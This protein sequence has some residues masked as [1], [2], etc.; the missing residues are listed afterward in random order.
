MLL[1]EENVI[2]LFGRVYVVSA[3]AGGWWL[4]AGE[5][6]RATCENN[7]TAD[8]DSRTKERQNERKRRQMKWKNVIDTQRVF[9]S[10]FYTLV[11]LP[12][13]PPEWQPVHNVAAHSVRCS[14]A[15]PLFA[16]CSVFSVIYLF[17]IR[18]RDGRAGAR[19]D[20][21]N[22][23]VCALPE[24]QPARVTLWRYFKCTQ[25]P[26][27]RSRHTHQPRSHSTILPN[28]HMHIYM[29]IARLITTQN[30]YATN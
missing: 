2:N 5:C 1:C 28:S 25:N 15:I 29:L 30:P 7:S 3:A 17:T 24:C 14:T 11:S 4:V 9:T 26:F 6:R 19:C 12:R 23:I 13:S 21:Y 16:I 18:I 8:N 27:R 20:E 22:A 10:R